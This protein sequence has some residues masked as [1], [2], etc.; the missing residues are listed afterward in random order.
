MSEAILD[1]LTQTSEGLIN[2]LDTGTAAAVEQATL[3]FAQAIEEIRAIGGWHE[4][5]EV[6][7][8]LKYAMQLADA[9]RARV[10]YLTDLNRRRY[11][12]LCKAA[13]IEAPSP[14]YNRQARLSA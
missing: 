14:A 12:M 7:A 13:G 1:R 2:A 6:L 5:T 3:A 8:K 4:S 9:A 11:E 10:N